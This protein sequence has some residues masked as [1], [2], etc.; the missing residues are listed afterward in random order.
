MIF[1]GSV[2]KLVQLVSGALAVGKVQADLFDASKKRRL[3]SAYTAVSGVAP[4][5]AL[6]T[7]AAFALANPYDSGVDLVVHEGSVGYLS[8]TLGAGFIAYGSCGFSLTAVTGTAIVA[9]PGLVGGG[10]GRGKAFTTATVATPE[11]VRILANLQ[12]SLATSVTPPWAITDKV[13]GAI[14][15]PPGC[16]VALEGVSA[17]GSTPLV[18]LGMT[19]EEIAA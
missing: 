1:E 4:G 16:A 15:I 7:T 13:D 11:I 6:G 17:A 9:R 5:T 12:A 19:W 8:G 18:I 14:V 3:F 10:P 2:G